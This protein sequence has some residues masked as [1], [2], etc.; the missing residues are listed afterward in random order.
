MPARW[1]LPL[2]RSPPAPASTSATSTAA[3]LGCLPRIAGL[4]DDL[5][6]DAAGGQDIYLDTSV[7]GQARMTKA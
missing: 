1:G 6:T 7:S 5:V 4:W 3:F 2:G